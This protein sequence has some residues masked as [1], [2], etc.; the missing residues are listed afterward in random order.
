[1]PLTDDV[2]GSLNGCFHQPCQHIHGL[3]LRRR[4]LRPGKRP[5]E[6]RRQ[7]L[8]QEYR[9]RHCAVPAA[10][11][12]LQ[13][14]PFRTSRWEGEDRIHGNNTAYTSVDVFHLCGS[15]ITVRSLNGAGHCYMAYTLSQPLNSGFHP[16][17]GLRR[18]AMGPAKVQM[19]QVREHQ[20]MSPTL[21][22]HPAGQRWRRDQNWIR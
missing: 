2:V 17:R 5:P 10:S 8:P 9:I 22:A 7:Y 19:Q 11:S 1:M 18:R 13:S 3:L 20:C 15:I 4:V 16:R 21:V 12:A 6:Y 14:Q